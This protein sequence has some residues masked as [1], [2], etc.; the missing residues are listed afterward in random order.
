MASKKNFIPG[1][2]N[3]SHQSLANLQFVFLPPFHIKLR[4]MKIFVKALD[5]E[6][7]A[8]LHLRNKFQKLSEA[9]VKEGVLLSHKLKQPFMMKCLKMNC[10]KQKKQPSWH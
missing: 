10:H 5:R 6:G 4:L 7:V 3:I 9:K 2:K 1:T 8:F